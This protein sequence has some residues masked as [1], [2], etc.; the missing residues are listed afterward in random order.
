MSYHL[1]ALHL[2]STRSSRE[3][4]HD[5]LFVPTYLS[6][7]RRLWDIVQQ[8]KVICRK[9]G[10]IF[11]MFRTEETVSDANE[12]TNI[13]LVKCSDLNLLSDKVPKFA[14]APEIPEIDRSR[15]FRYVYLR[16]GRG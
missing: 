14:S 13:Y 10:D 3:L 4:R 2:N 6:N 1:R 11:S 16:G 5:H 8:F 7:R 9:R 12:P 15:P